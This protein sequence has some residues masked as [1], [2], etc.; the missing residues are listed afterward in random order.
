M[1]TREQFE[2]FVPAF[3][4][5][6]DVDGD[7][8]YDRVEP[9]IAEEEQELIDLLVIKLDAIPD[10]ARHYARQVI[11]NRAAA[12]AIDHLDLTLTP[13]GFGV[14][15][16]NRVAPASRQRIDALTAALQR[17]A[18]A[19]YDRLITELLATP[20]GETPTAWGFAD[21]L[22]FLPSICRSYG[23]TH[24]GQEIYDKQFAIVT[25]SLMQAE[26]DVEAILSTELYRKLIDTLR[27]K[28]TTDNAIYHELLHKARQLTALCF[29]VREI[30]QSRQTLIPAIEH[31][32][33]F[34]AENAHQLP[35]WNSS[36]T[37]AAQRTTPYQ[38]EKSAPSFFFGM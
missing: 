14:V 38:N 17:T 6:N 36:A 35:E 18:S 30:G 37:A 21:R 1:L 9:F 12:R 2:L 20:W 24:D 32:Q 19:L 5:P 33:R 22:I 4:Q 16:N 10:Q 34:I 23:I 27:R 8:I 28:L 29:K 25:P 13:E 3:K 15:N 7:Y 26:R 31:L 11:A